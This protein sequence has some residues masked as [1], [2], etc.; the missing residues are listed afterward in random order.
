M[1]Q[2]QKNLD[3]QM[4]IEL[5]KWLEQTMYEA[6]WSGFGLE[7]RKLEENQI[8]VF[9]D[10][11][12]TEPNSCRRCTAKWPGVLVTSYIRKIVSEYKEEKIRVK[13]VKHWNILLTEVMKFLWN[14]HRV[15]QSN[16][17]VNCW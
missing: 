11:N 14:I 4:V 1:C 9:S 16:F 17:E 3:Q 12:L 15:A 5:I 8:P 2:S 10:R 13:I 7:K 6:E